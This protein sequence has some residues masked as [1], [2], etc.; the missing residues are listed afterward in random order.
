MIRKLICQGANIFRLN[1]SHVNDK[2][3]EF[4]QRI[5][6]I[7]QI[8]Q[9]E[10]RN[11]A[12]LGDLQG[13]KIRTGKVK[14]GTV[15]K[16][17]DILKITTGESIEGDE[18]MVS[19]TYRDMSKDVKPGDRILID[20]GLLEVQVK[21]VDGNIISCEVTHGGQLKS[22]K[23][24]NLPNVALST[25]ALTE[26]DEFDLRF[27]VENNLDF[28]A[29]SFVRNAE[30]IGKINKIIRRL[31]SDIAVIAKIEKPEA[32]NESAIN[33]IIEASYG[34]MV[35]RGD[36]GVEMETAEVPVIQKKIVQKCNNEGKPV[37]IATQMLDSM[38]ANPRPTRAE[39]NDVANAVLD[40]A[41]CV[42][43][44]GETASGKFP[45]ESVKTMREIIELVE[46]K[47]NH[48]K[49]QDESDPIKFRNFTNESTK[50]IC[51]AAV[52]IAKDMQ[53][54]LILC[55]THSGG[56]A[57]QLSKYRPGIPIIAITDEDKI[58]RR[59]A[60]SWGIRAYKL[61]VIIN[62]PVFFKGLQEILSEK[63]KV[64]DGSTVIITGGLPDFKEKTTNML[65]IHTHN[66]E[67]GIIS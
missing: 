48:E 24:M 45:E 58:V 13:P 23:G 1:F 4:K 31:N 39:A 52:R 6:T 42:M 10:Q 30:D 27:A 56:T 59:L 53:A 37:I 36:L 40:G 67:S 38:Q 63:L 25:P 66:K 62:S 5:Q 7:R 54:K 11:I 12:I 33:A 51:R 50:L 32:V 28:I 61:P 22:N 8:A 35:A 2:H 47:I 19:T 55:V 46:K 64:E 9:E 14:D 60:L 20:D 57:R 29:L 43:L 21:S 18:H 44:S 49:W 15:I 26:K 3:D 41:D 34:I 65:K 17:G 16:K